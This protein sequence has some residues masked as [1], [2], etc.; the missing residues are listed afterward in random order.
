M[1]VPGATPTPSSM[2]WTSRLCPSRRA[3]T[4][5]V[6]SRS[7]RPCSTALVTNSARTVASA[8]AVSASTV[9]KAPSRRVVTAPV[10]V[11][12]RAAPRRIEAKTSSKSTF[13]STLWLR[14][15]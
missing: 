4:V 1:I 10:A 12:T 8:W 14:A 15:S 9:P 5:T 13:S 2:T 11:A 6:P 3:R 7:P